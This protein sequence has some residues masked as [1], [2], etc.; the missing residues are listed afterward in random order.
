MNY[1]NKTFSVHAP[2]TDE[3]RKRWE[4]TFRTSCGSQFPGIVDGY[5]APR[6]C[7]CNLEKD[8]DGKHSGVFGGI[9]REW[10]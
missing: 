8:H 4:Q 2:G 6:E 10:V 9:P 7:K 3:Y 1:T 5:R